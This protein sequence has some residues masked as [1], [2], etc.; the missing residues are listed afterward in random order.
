MNNNIIPE[1][2]INL[3]GIVLYE[4]IELKPIFKRLEKLY[5]LFP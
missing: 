3:K 4:K 5:L 2:V 1:I